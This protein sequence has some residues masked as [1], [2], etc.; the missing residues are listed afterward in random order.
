MRS[1]DLIEKSLGSPSQILMA[2]EMP[3]QRDLP[4]RPSSQD[5]LVKYPRN[6][7]DSDRLP[8][9]RVLYLDDQA[10]CTLTQWADQAPS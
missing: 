6:A 4:Q 5:D 8:A 1:L 10:V 9:E 7:L 2:L 3:Q